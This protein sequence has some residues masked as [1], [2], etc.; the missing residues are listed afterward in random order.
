[1]NGFMRRDYN[2][3]DRDGQRVRSVRDVVVRVRADRPAGQSAAFATR[4]AELSEPEGSFDTDNLISNERVVS[5]RRPGAA[6]RPASQ[7]ARISAS[8]RIR[9][10]RTSRSIRPAIA[11]IVD[12]RRDNLLLHLLFKALFAEAPT[13]IDY[14]TLLFGRAPPA[15]ADGWKTAPIERLAAYVSGSQAR[16]GRRSAPRAPRRGARPIGRAALAR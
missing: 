12:I 8:A 3:N 10:S 4:I 6:E 2:P 7:A 15:A 13:R 14:L 1:M 11:F 9:I 5:A 16:V